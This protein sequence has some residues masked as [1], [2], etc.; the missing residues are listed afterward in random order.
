MDEMDEMDG[1]DRNP[2]SLASSQRSHSVS[3]SILSMPS[4]SVHFFRG[5]KIP[6][7]LL[8]SF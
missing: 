6:I 5:K 8:T 3:P 1:M 4:I 2:E 7:S